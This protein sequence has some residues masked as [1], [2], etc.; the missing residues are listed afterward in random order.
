MPPMRD[1]AA[2]AVADL[3]SGFGL[4][5]RLPIPQ[6]REGGTGVTPHRAQ[7]A[8]CWPLVGVVI[9]ALM[10]LVGWAGH[11]LGLPGG[12]TA[13]AL[14]ATAAIATGA[15]HEDGLADTFDGLF[16][17]WTPERRLEI[18]KDSHIGSFG[19]LALLLVVL[20]KWSALTALLDQG[21][22]GA[23]IAVAALSRAP[24]AVVMTALPNA[25]GAGLA[26]TVGRPG[27][28]AA[29]I[30]CGI[31]LGVAGSAAPVTAALMMALVMALVA[32][33]VAA[34]ARSRLGGQTGDILGATQVL[35]ETAGL[36]VLASQMV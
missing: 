36:A 26:Q 20:A 33:A 6:H 35:C 7:A 16:G 5:T 18:M 21:A 22:L 31:G 25:R 4:L 19:T 14:L 34:L 30:A 10:A 1:I 24:M 23:I 9:G 15:L 12:V 2:Q 27:A 3:Q 28:P 32:V 17:G 11:G 8:W 29:L 13:A